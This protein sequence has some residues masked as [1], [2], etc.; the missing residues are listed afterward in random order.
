MIPVA[1]F[2]CM[3][4]ASVRTVN[5]ER[6]PT[7]ERLHEPPE[8]SRTLAYHQVDVVRHDRVREDLKIGKGDLFTQE[9]DDPGPYLRR[10]ERLTVLEA[11]GQ[12]KR[13]PRQVGA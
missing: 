12:V 2:E 9:G 6:H 13:A 8:R 1:P 5:Q 10:E 7:Q 3:P 11:C 4:L